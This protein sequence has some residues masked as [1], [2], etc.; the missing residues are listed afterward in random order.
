MTRHGE[1]QAVI[2]ELKHWRSNRCILWPYSV[3]SWGYPHVSILADTPSGRTTV[4]VSRIMAEHLHGA[5]PQGALA[6]HICD[7]PRCINPQHIRWGDQR[8]N[9]LQA[10]LQGRLRRGANGRT[11]SL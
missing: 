4:K 11:L 8:D 1:A 10:R 3:D 5:P 9:L 7:T 2:E 6:L